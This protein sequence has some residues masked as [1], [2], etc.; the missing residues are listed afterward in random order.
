M[1][2][3]AIANIG[4]LL[5]MIGNAGNAMGIQGDN[6]QGLNALQRLTMTPEQSGAL[7]QQTQAAST[8]INLSDPS[9]PQQVAV[10]PAR[11]AEVQQYMNTQ[12]MQ[13]LQP[14]TLAN[15][16]S[17]K[18]NGTLSG[19]DALGSQAL[20]AAYASND[21]GKVA[22]AY[23]TLYEHNP[24][25]AGR[26]KGE[27]EG[28]TLFKSPEGTYVLGKKLGAGAGG[29][30]IPTQTPPSGYP[31]G[32]PWQGMQ[33]SSPAVNPSPMS[34][35]GNGG[36]VI[37]SGD[38]QTQASPAGYPSGLPVQ[39]PAAATSNLLSSDG[40][41]I[42]PQV[43]NAKIPADP[44]GTPKYNVP[45]T[46]TGVALQ[47][48]FQTSDI[49]SNEAM[50]SSLNSLQTEQFR[51]KQ[52]GDIYHL[53]QA[54]T[55][56]AQNPEFFNKMAA[57][58]FKDDPES[59]KQLGGIQAAM[60]NHILK[61]INQIKDTNANM[62][63]APTRTFG[64][65]ISQLLE[66]GENPG[67][68]PN[69]LFNVLTQ[70]KGVVDHHIDMVKGWNDV[71]GLGN[72]LANGNTMR[73]DDFVRNWSLNHNIEDYRSKAEKEMPAFKGTPQN[74]STPKTAIKYQTSPSTGK[75]K[76]IYSDGTEEIK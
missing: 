42:I 47:K 61:V 23:K 17:L 58:G 50:N 35:Q 30:S 68:Q 55:L 57:M 76:I 33:Q 13:A 18:S 6:P 5:G 49:K 7:Y 1:T 38:N 29:A 24:D 26:I 37:L 34:P 10:N 65:E 73:P 69:G 66:E 62:G 14:I 28:N 44:S 25:L 15:L 56:T 2:A 46:E 45:N 60:Q 21:M 51:I 4:N 9:L 71:G 53:V 52:L 40:K 41:P 63:A 12:R 22:D 67:N 64:A 70:A 16:E 74:P 39:A 75:T 32:L 43:Q 11:G 20:M 48:D 72:R 54:G 19:P 59:I 27:Q 36:P 8:P 31:K 3:N